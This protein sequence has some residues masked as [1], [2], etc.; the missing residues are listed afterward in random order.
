MF[1]SNK[2]I[3][4]F[5]THL[6]SLDKATIKY[7]YK[8]KL[9]HNGKHAT[10]V[11]HQGLIPVFNHKR[12]DFS[13]SE[14]GQKRWD[15]LQRTRQAIYDIADTNVGRFKEMPI[16]CTFTF[17][18]NVT[19]IS[20]AN[21]LWKS[22]I[23]RF[24]RKYKFNPKYITVVEF[25][26]RGSVHF[27]TLFFNLPFIP[28]LEFERVW[29]YGFTNM[30]ALQTIRNISAYLCKYLTKETSDTRL[31]GQKVYF[32]S[33]GLLRPQLTRD[34]IEIE[35]ILHG[36]EVVGQKQLTKKIIHKYKYAN[37]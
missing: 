10:L 36:Y 30:K 18:E 27:H 7:M 9:V 34:S 37:S 32:C 13:R 21:K 1:K 20:D 24:K 26:K 15:S 19:E 23:K 16:F 2:Q 35:S 12:V 6:T 3:G 25:Q 29:G 22:Y 4:H 28:V 14:T 31:Y 33:R 5:R 17:K 11:E 8:E